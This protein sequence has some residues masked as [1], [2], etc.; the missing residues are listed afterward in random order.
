MRISDWSSD[1]C[2]SDLFVRLMTSD[3]AADQEVVEKIGV[4]F[5][6]QDGRGTH[7]NISGAGVLKYAPN[8]ETA[9]KFLEYLASDDAQKYFASANYDFPAVER[10]EVAEVVADL[11]GDFKAAPLNVSYS[12]EIGRAAGREEE[13]PAG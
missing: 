7:V 11:G 4:V 5:P 6:N 8:Q 1:V 13:G 12:G 9:V 10:I 3:K 2:S